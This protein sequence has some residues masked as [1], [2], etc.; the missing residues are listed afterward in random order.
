MLELLLHPSN[1]PFSVALALLLLIGLVEGVGALFGAG[2]SALLD[3]ML[4]DLEVDVDAPDL[5]GGDGPLSSLWS[6][7]RVGE[8]PVI[9]LLVIF[10]TAFGLLGFLLQSSIAGLVGAP[11]PAWLAS[12]PAA[13]LAL[14]V[15]RLSGR[16]LGR[17]LPKEQTSAIRGADLVGRVGTVVLGTAS[18]GNAAQIKVVGPF[19]RSHY[20][21]AEPEDDHVSFSQGEQVLLARFDGVQFR[22]VAAPEALRSR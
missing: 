13:F 1:L 7:L 4:P 10:L 21:L 2:L 22:I 19:G 9:V 12:I 6:W 5:E 8:V 15:V 16:T 18:R 17:L 3:S 14:P 11:L 20:Y